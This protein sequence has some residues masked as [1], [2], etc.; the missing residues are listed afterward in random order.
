MIT[1]ARP[2]ASCSAEDTAKRINER[3]I[4][5]A[6]IMERSFL[7]LGVQSIHDGISYKTAPFGRYNFSGKFFEALRK[8]NFVLFRQEGGIATLCQCHENSVEDDLA[9][10]RC[11][12]F[13][14]GFYRNEQLGLDLE[15]VARFGKWNKDV[16]F[17]A[18]AAGDFVTP[19]CESLHRQIF[20]AVVESDPRA[21]KLV[22]MAVDGG[23]EINVSLADMG[24]A[25]LRSLNSLFVEFSHK[26][27][28]REGRAENGKTYRPDP[29]P[30]A[31]EDT[32]FLAEKYHGMIFD[33][34]KQQ[35][36]D[37]LTKAGFVL[38]NQKTEELPHTAGQ[39]DHVVLASAIKNFGLENLPQPQHAV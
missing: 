29:L 32:L 14:G 2:M 37:Y 4:S 17:T 16:V 10:D 19:D 30:R 13:R 11:W 5:L 8:R 31:P 20:E 28:D 12:S 9:P 3:L 35:E 25:G 21:S 33:L 24:F 6:E 39:S 23:G 34:W 18:R 38:P 36:E 7:F 22:A 15:L 1:I 26:R 27:F